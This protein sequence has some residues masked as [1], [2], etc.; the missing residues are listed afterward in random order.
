MRTGRRRQSGF[1]YVGVLLLVAVLGIALAATSTV[2]HFQ[3]Q[4]EKERELLS[5]GDEF[6]LALDRYAANSVGTARRYPTRLEDLLLD[7]R[8]AGKRRHLRRIYRDPMTGRDE[9]GLVRTADGQI[10]GIYSLSTEPTIKRANFS[11]RDQNFTGMPTYRQWI[12]MATYART[13]MRMRPAAPNNSFGS[14]GTVKVN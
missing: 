11:L 8:S 9:W 14:S 5:I 7:D 6:R 13:A 1:T 2:W 10:I 3:V 4:R 12:F